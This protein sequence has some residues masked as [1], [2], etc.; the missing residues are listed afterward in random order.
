MR[1]AGGTRG[2]G[3]NS[4]R[5]GWTKLQHDNNAKLKFGVFRT[6][7]EKS[8][9]TNTQN[10]IRQWFARYWVSINSSPFYLVFYFL[11]ASEY[12]AKG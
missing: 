11:S 8:T 5:V 9:Q 6:N 1:S 12:R 4:R 10:F 3:K 7:I 2:R